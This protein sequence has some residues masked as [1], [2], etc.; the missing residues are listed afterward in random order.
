MRHA[1]HLSSGVLLAVL[2]ACNAAPP[3]TNAT[4]TGVFETASIPN[5][6][7][8]S[9]ALVEVNVATGQ[10]RINWDDTT[11]TEAIS[12]SAAVPGG[13]YHLK[14]LSAIDGSDNIHWQLYRWDAKSGR[15]WIAFANNNN[16]SSLHWTELQPSS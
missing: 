2:A 8:Q 6:P 9:G 11:T 14:V 16:I 10:A 1:E 4:A 7:S 13:A 3:A 5:S 12:D 15:M